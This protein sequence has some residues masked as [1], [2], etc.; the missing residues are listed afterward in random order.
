M[1]GFRVGKEKVRIAVPDEEQIRTVALLLA[2]TADARDWSALRALFT[3]EVTIDYE[4]VSGIAPSK[5]KADDLV[6]NWAKGLG[7]YAQTRHNFSGFEVKQN[8]DTAVCLFTGEA[9]H[10]KPNGERWSC[11]GDYTHHLLRTPAGW[12]ITAAEFEMRWEQGIR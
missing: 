2:S 9:T 1:N 4:S 12:K 3:E 11:G 6:A 10:L 8:G 5:I 7:N